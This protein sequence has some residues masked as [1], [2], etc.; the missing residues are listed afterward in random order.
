M[1]KFDQ[2]CVILIVFVLTYTTEYWKS[3]GLQIIT[4]SGYTVCQITDRL[5]VAQYR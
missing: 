1:T 3:K 4:L 2:D 5:K